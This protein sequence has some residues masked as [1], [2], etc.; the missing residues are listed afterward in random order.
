MKI[1]KTECDLEFA[2]HELIPTEEKCSN[3]ELFKLCPYIMRDYDYEVN[4]R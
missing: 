3:C 2:N 4:D 1:S